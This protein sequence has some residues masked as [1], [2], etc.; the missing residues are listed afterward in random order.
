MSALSARVWMVT[1]AVEDFRATSARS[2]DQL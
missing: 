1:V 2:D